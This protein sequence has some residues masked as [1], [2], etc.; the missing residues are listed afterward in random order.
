MPLS[1]DALYRALVTSVA[2]PN[3]HD[4]RLK[5]GQQPK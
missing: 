5:N 2:D 3:G 4:H 1:Y